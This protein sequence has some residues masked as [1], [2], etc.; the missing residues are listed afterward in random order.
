M[1]AESPVSHRSDT[2]A[3][4]LSQRL[5]RSARA[6]LICSRVLP[7]F[8]CVACEPTSQPST[9]PVSRQPASQ[10]AASQQ[11]DLSAARKLVLGIRTG[12][13]SELAC[14]TAI[15]RASRARQELGSLRARGR[16][17]AMYDGP[18]TH[19][20]APVAHALTGLPPPHYHRTHA[21][22]LGA[23]HVR[24]DR[25]YP[26]PAPIYRHTVYTIHIHTHE[27]TKTVLWTGYP[28]CLPTD[29]GVQVLADEYRTGSPVLPVS[30]HIGR[31]L[32]A[33]LGRADKTHTHT[34]RW[35]TSGCGHICLALPSFRLAVYVC[36]CVCVCVYVL[37][38]NA[39]W[40]CLNEFAGSLIC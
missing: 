31:D 40:C 11:A 5:P 3:P 28:H 21:H 13:R 36:V 30:V 33:G 32:T 20:L 37:G 24:T 4:W 9:P 15:G 12:Y 34:H 38:L 25:P 2:G 39:C 23:R 7:G 19:T 10:A 26:H 35:R 14:I 17:V 1:H 18:H 16:E 6:V 29:K 8:F 22:T 27:R